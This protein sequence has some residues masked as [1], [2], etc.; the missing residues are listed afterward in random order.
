MIEDRWFIDMTTEKII[1]YSSA[2]NI[3]AAYFHNAEAAK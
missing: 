2:V 3:A 1:K